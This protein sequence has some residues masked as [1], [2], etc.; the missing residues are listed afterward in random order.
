MLS[1]VTLLTE[2]RKVNPEMDSKLRRQ[3][4]IFDTQSD[5]QG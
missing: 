5:Y 1:A 4:R 3:R 2:D